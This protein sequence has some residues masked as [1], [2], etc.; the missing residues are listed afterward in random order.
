MAL[1]KRLEILFGVKAVAA[2]V[3]AVAMLTGAPAS[4]KA[5]SG[6]RIAVGLP[7][8]IVFGGSGRD[9]HR[10]GHQRRDVHRG[11]HTRQD[12][13]RGG[14]RLDYGRDHDRRRW[15]KK[16]ARYDDD[17]GRHR[18][19]DDRRGWSDRRGDRGDRHGR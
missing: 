8:V 11:G 10:N 3:L 7:G 17:R 6:V 5:D 9:Y 14:H 15:G 18:G 19:R 13:R 16:Y 4:V 1:H 12:V 2:V